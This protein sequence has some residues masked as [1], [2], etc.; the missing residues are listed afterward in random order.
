MHN[1][2]VLLAAGFLL[3]LSACSKPQTPQAQEPGQQTPPAEAAPAAAIDACALLTSEEIAAVQGEPLQ[4]RKPAQKSDRGLVISECFLALP[5]FT[6]SISLTLAQDSA[7]AGAH[8]VK[9]FWTETFLEPKKIPKSGGAQKVP[10]LGDDAF[11]MG[12]ERLGALFVLKG[13]RY[14]RIS[15]G[16]AGDQQAK[17][18]K[19][20]ALA[21]AILKRL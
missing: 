2:S 18:E 17:I 12:D 6:N 13:N 19:C 9:Q 10:D 1:C 14:V 21:E 11:W 4:E 16:G 8:T 20:R 5:T 3:G 7:G 15:V